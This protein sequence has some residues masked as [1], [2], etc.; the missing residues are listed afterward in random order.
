[1]LTTYLLL[2]SGY[3]FVPFSSMEAV[4]E[5]SKKGYYLALHQTQGTIKN[6]QPNWEP[7]VLF[8][9]RTMKQ[10]KERLEIKIEREQMLKAK[11]PELSL[12]I[13]ELV[14]SRGRITIS[15]VVTLTNANRN[16]IKKHLEQLVT[17]NHLEKNGIRKGV[18]YSIK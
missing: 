7:W 10:Q 16:T 2:L 5:N 14:K 3:E 11:L 1:L 6:D 4:I 13:L 12:K 9:L 17:E 15:E 8:F 18:W